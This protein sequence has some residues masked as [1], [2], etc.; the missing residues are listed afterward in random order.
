MFAHVMCVLIYPDHTMTISD[1]VNSVVC[2]LVLVQGSCYDAA[3]PVLSQQGVLKKYSAS[4]ALNAIQTVSPASIQL[5]VKSPANLVLLDNMV[6]LAVHMHE[7][8][9]SYV[10]PVLTL[11]DTPNFQAC[12]FEYNQWSGHVIYHDIDGSMHQYST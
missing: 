12:S 10:V 5:S 11:H 8:F 1:S 6:S 3:Y 7:H 2:Q 4:P 9:S